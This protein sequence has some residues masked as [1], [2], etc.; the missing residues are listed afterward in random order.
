MERECSTD[1]A[2]NASSVGRIFE[3]CDDRSVIRVADTFASRD[4]LLLVDV[5]Y[6]DLIA[7]LA[8]ADAA[9]FPEQPVLYLEGSLSG[10][11][12]CMV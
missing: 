10:S 1:G 6:F 12:R 2:R 11:K 3:E 7:S 8:N 5:E 4:C 9:P